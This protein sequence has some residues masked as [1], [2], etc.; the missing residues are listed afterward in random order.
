MLTD[1][2]TRPNNPDGSKYSVALIDTAGECTRVPIYLWKDGITIEDAAFKQLCN[3][4]H[5]KFVHH[6]IAAMPD[7]HFGIG[8][9]V[10]SVFGSVGADI[11]ASVGVDI[12]CGMIAA[13]TNLTRSDIVDNQAAHTPTT[14]MFLIRQAIEARIP[15]GRTNN[16]R[17]GDRGAWHDIPEDVMAVWTEKLEAGYRFHTALYPALGIGNDVNHLGTLGTGNHFI[18]IQ[19]DE[20]DQ[21]WIMLHSGS[22]GVGNRIGN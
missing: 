1:N 4:S 16:G 15:M 18:E 5:M 8:A 22:R 11:P 3:L 9:T 12:G 2:L 20:N 10:G 13:R 19:Y 7:A 21:V 6:H 14:P 17:L